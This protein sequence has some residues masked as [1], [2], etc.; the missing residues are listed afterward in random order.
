MLILELRYTVINFNCVATKNADRYGHFPQR[1]PEF[2]KGKYI[3]NR[4]NLC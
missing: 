3:P 4:N 2:P 1:L